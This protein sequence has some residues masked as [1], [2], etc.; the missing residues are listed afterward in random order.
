M[1]KEKKAEAALSVLKIVVLLDMV[2]SEL[3]SLGHNFKGEPKQFINNTQKGIARR[4]GKMIAEVFNV[5]IQRDSEN[6]EMIQEKIHELIEENV[7][8]TE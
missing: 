3:I 7:N 1:T 4:F 6:L 5:D 8:I 2:D